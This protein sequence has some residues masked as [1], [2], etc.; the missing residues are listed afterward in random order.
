MGKSIILQETEDTP[1]VELDPENNKFSI[2][3]RSLPEDTSEFYKPIINWMKAYVKQPNPYTEF[4]LKMEY[5]NSSSIKQIVT[6]LVILSEI[7]K[8]GKEVKI[9]W[10]YKEG[11]DLMEIKGRELK[12]MIAVP[13]EA[14]VY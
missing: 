11:D 2:S 3:G 7:I 12:S 4:Q 13:F 9:T 14:K 5:F 1:Q 8:T 6:L 10:H